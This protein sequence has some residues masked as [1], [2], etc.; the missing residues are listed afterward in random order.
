MSYESMP[1]GK[2][3]FKICVD[4]SLGGCENAHWR[5]LRTLLV[6]GRDVL[7]TQFLVLVSEICLFVLFPMGLRTNCNV[8]FC[9]VY[10]IILPLFVQAACVGSRDG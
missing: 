6:S 4:G 3:K 10:H 1:G 8:H 5:A 7:T 2:R 9:L